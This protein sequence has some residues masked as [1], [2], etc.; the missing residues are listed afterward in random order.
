MVQV[1]RARRPTID[2]CVAHLDQLIRA[3]S[4]Y[5]LRAQVW[6]STDNIFGF[7]YRFFPHWIRRIIFIVTQTP[8]I[9]TT[10]YT[11]SLS[12]LPWLPESQSSDLV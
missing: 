12:P 3:Q 10:D 6:H 7:I 11:Y 8:A 9:P 5:S 1:D 2:Q 4:S